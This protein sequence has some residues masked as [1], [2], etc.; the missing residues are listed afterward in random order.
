MSN[1]AKPIDPVLKWK[2]ES[3]R[4]DPMKWTIETYRN[5]TDLSV[6]NIHHCR[7]C[8]FQ[9]T[10]MRTN[11]NL[12][13][14]RTGDHLK[15][16]DADRST[17][18]LRL[19]SAHRWAMIGWITHLQVVPSRIPRWNSAVKN[20]E[21]DFF[22]IN[23]HIHTLEIN[24]CVRHSLSPHTHTHTHMQSF[25]SASIKCLMYMTKLPAHYCIWLNARH[26]G[27]YRQAKKGLFQL[28]RAVWSTSEVA[29]VWWC[30][31]WRE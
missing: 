22:H 14:D 13:A 12:S 23:A 3:E 30:C 25:T 11:W 8:Y 19:T 29:D 24:H 7:Y 20:L 31:E 15:R 5:R 16:T 28:T 6:T 26:Q 27:S 21:R 17:A 1:W 9:N 4:V 18:A 10:S 2:T